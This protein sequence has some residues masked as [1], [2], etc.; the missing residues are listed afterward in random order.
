[1]K[2]ARKYLLPIGGPLVVIAAVT[3]STPRPV[4]ALAAAL[5][6]VTNTFTNPVISQPTN[7]AASQLIQ[8]QPFAGDVTALGSQ[9]LA[10]YNPATS[11]TASTPYTV[12]SGENLVITDVDLNFYAVAGDIGILFYNGNNVPTQF[13]QFYERL[14]FN[15]PAGTLHL[16]YESGMVFPS[17][18]TV[19]VTSATSNQNA[20]TIVYVRGYLTAN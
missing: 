6:Q 9:V 2:Y 7:T 15:N 10:Q 4:H 3:L 12:P 17:G 16:H 5:V 8:L 18:A 14:D 20:Y 1:M 11:S 19:G 13:N